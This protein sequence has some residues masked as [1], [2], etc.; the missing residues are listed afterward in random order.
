MIKILFIL[1]IIFVILFSC[2]AVYWGVNM[3]LFKR[4][5]VFKYINRARNSSFVLCIAAL[6]INI[7]NLIVQIIKLSN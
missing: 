2:S 5:K 7:I 3:F 6:C 4:K 1:F